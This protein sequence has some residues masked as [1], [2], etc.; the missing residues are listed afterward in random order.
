MNLDFGTINYL[1]VIL[2]AVAICILGSFWYSPMIF[3]NTWQTL[4]GLKQEDL[5]S[6]GKVMTG[7]ILMAIVNS[8]LLAIIA[9]WANIDGWAEGLWLGLVVGLVIAATSATNALYEGM[10]LKLYMITAGFHVISIIIAGIIIGSF[11]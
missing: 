11:S 10:K 9:Q 2:G 3:W 5:P 8:F 1:A 7:S 4:K 6:L